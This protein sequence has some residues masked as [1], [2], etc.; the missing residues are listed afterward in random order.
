MSRHQSCL[1]NFMYSIVLPSLGNCSNS[2]IN[3]SGETLVSGSLRR[4][5]K[6]CGRC[7]EVLYM[8]SYTYCNICR[9]VLHRVICSYVCCQYVIMSTRITRI[10]IPIVILA[11]GIIYYYIAPENTI[12]IPKCPWWLITGTYCPS[13]GIQRLLHAL[14]T[15]RILEALCINP[16][17]LISI[18]YAF[19]AVLGKWYNING[20]FDRM[21][22]FIYS[23]R[24]LIAYVIL[25]FSWWVI[26]IIFSI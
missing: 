22:K 1:G 5:S 3:I 19:F 20:V 25:F 16:F 13:C 6:S 10:I 24:V 14:L 12:W 17:L 23:R 15:G 21:N 18:P 7:K 2:K 9:I 11:I 4:S 26:R 8:G